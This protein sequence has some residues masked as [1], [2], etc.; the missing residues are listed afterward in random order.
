MTLDTTDAKVIACYIRAS[1]PGYKGPV[2]VDLAKLKELY[3]H[4]S[5]V[6]VNNILRKAKQ[7]SERED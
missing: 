2:F 5:A 7:T 3:M 6:T 1:N 4:N